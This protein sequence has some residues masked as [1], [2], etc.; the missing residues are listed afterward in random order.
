MGG[1]GG[2]GVC[3]RGGG[4]DICV[5]DLN[6]DIFEWVSTRDHKLDDIMD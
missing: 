3:C 1:G 2:G 4:V 5:R 6:F